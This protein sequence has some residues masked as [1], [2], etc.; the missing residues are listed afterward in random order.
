M[1]RSPDPRRRRLDKPSRELVGLRCMSWF[2]WSTGNF[3][4]IA[5][6]LEAGIGGRSERERCDWVRGRAR[7]KMLYAPGE[8]QW[9]FFFQSPSVA[10]A[11]RPR[12]PKSHNQRATAETLAVAMDFAEALRGDP[13]FRLGFNSAGSSASVNHLHFQVCLSAMRGLPLARACSNAFRA[14]SVSSLTPTL[15]FFLYLFRIFFPLCSADPSHPF[16]DTRLRA[17]P[18]LGVLVL[19]FPF[20]R[21]QK[22]E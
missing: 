20:T 22:T 15:F 5:E 16:R 13:G 8:D 11:R 1:T 2:S 3:G 10:R 19:Y 9:A 7:C 4:R 18:P 17:R 12:Y 14:Q 6:Q 21:T